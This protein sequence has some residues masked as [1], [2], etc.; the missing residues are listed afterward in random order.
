MVEE[1]LTFSKYLKHDLIFNDRKYI[2]NFTIISW[3]LPQPHGSR[4]ANQ[5]GQIDPVV[6]Q[7]SIS[8]IEKVEIVQNKLD[9]ILIYVNAIYGDENT[10]FLD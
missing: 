8:D 1:I 9:E 2:L 10:L 7:N 4:M 5:N 6:M 3:F